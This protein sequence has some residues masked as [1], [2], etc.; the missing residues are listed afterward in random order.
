MS[1]TKGLKKRISGIRDT[2][3]ITNAMYL[4]ASAKL[5][6]ARQELDNTR[7]YFEALKSEIKRIFR[8]DPKRDNKFFYPVGVAHD[9][10]G[11]YGYLVITADKG[12]SGSYNMNVIKTALNLM[13]Q[14]S[15]NELYVVGQYGRH[16]F[17]SHNIPIKDNFLY[18]AQNPTFARARQI[19]DVLLDGYLSGRL[20]KIYVIYTDYVSGVKSDIYVTRLLP[21]HRSDFLDHV[22]ERVIKEPFEFSPSA[23]E[24]LNN[25]VPSYVAGFIYS[26]L[27]DSYCSEQNSRM[28]AMKTANDNAQELLESLTLQ[29]NH[30]RQSEITA[31][32]TE[33]SAGC[34]GKEMS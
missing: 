3:K 6:K 5:S 26:A 25:I 18:T 28:T 12:L 7:P 8:I 11:A 17:S 24:V 1:S 16:Y 2:K 31:E 29:Y 32:I 33:I 27:I 10:Q 34:L 21:F 20:K 22:Q 4:I 13:K 14:H 23:E 15:E 30:Q 9:L 19:C